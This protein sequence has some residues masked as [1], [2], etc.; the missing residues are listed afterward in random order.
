MQYGT[1]VFIIPKKGE[2]GTVC[3][4]FN[5]RCLNQTI[6]QKP[7]LRIPRIGA[8]QCSF[9]YAATALDLNMC[10]YT[11]QLTPGTKD[12]NLVNSDTTT[13]GNHVLVC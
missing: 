5:Y 9:Q 1:P 12:I 4:L 8:Q 7:Y 10:Y 6:V 11:I 13:N 3:F 2:A